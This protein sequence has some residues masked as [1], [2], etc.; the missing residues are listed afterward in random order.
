MEAGQ[1]VEYA[2][3]YELLQK[4]DG[5]F[6]RMVQQTGK[7]MEEHLREVAKSCYAKT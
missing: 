4:P 7:Q 1:A 5:Y 2:H 6:T 3:P